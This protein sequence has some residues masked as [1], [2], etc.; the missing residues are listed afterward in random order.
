M[1]F[2]KKKTYLIDL[3][4]IDC[5]NHLL[6]KVDDGFRKEARSLGAIATMADMGVKKI[7]FTPHVNP[8]VYKT[9]NEATLRAAYENFK[10][11]IPN[12]WGVTTDLAAEYMI[13]TGF[14]E[15]ASAPELLTFKDNSLLMDMSYYFESP[16][17]KDVIFEL[18]LAG[19]KP[20]LAHPERYIYYANNLKIFDDIV[21]MGC[22]L[23]LN[24]MSLT[25]KYGPDSM[26]ILN[27]LL[28]NDMYSFICTDLHT[29]KQ[30]QSILEI[31]LDKSMYEQVERVKEK[32]NFAEQVF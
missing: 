9:Q 19:R 6:P 3:P 4:E 31:E 11:L 32:M 16:N 8:E 22:R 29:T 12:D 10:K 17:L 7:I 27:Y 23:Q 5:H 15:R 2:F 14:E 26:K 18:N 13:C 20:I 1:L 25:G 21:S 28:G 30:L 24:W